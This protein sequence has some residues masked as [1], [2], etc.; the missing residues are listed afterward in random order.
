MK[1][2]YKYLIYDYDNQDFLNQI[3]DLKECKKL[4]FRNWYSNKKKKYIIL[5]QFI[6]KNFY[7]PKLMKALIKDGLFVTFIYHQI[8]KNNPK[9][10]LTTADNDI[11]FYKL[12]KYFNNK[13][14]FMAIQNGARSKFHDIFD[15]PLLKKDKD[16][17]ADYYFSFGSG[18]KKI[19]EKHINVKVIPVGSIKSNMIKINEIKLRNKKINI[20]YV[21]SFRKKS[22]NEVFDKSIDGHTIYWNDFIRE[23]VKLIKLLGNYCLK[24]N[25]SLAVAGCSLEYHNIEKKFFQNIL[26]NV[27]WKFYRRQ[28][29]F[30]SYQLLDSFEIIVNCCGTLGYEALGRD[31]KVAFFSREISPYNDWR[32]GWPEKYTSKGLFHSNVI[33]QFEVNRILNNLK[34]INKS[35]WKS[36]LI[37]EKNKNMHY[38]FQNIK[39]KKFL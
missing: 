34:N 33:S 20:L 16:L 12:K 22:Q 28:N 32:F 17:A 7:N 1:K 23:E 13:I 11:R 24:N 6:I 8:L 5:F 30:S 2:K 35:D 39:I 10:V 3:I 9:I 25:I 29:K 14:K 37:K 27:K 36:A 19:I 31:K 38:D 18:L 26:T 15:N 4:N 21:S